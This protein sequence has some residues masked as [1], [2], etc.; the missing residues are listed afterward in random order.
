[1]SAPLIVTAARHTGGV[2][3]LS[4]AAGDGAPLASFTPGSH[5]TVEAGGRCNAY[6]LTG[7]YLNPR[8]YDISVLATPDGTGS[9]WLHERVE[10]GD[11]LMVSPPR[12]AFA[13][14]AAARHHVLVAGG[15]GVTPILS[16]VRA[17]VRHQRSFEVLYAHRSD[18]PAH[19]E[20]LIALCGPRLATVTDRHEL[21]SR[22]RLRL[23]SQP[24]GTVLSLCG[25][26]AMMA[27]VVELAG[28]LG[29]PGQRILTEAFGVDV[30]DPGQPFTARLRRSGRRI[31][32]A[33]GVSLLEALEADGVRVPN[34]CRQGVCGECRVPVAAGRPEHR[35][36]YLS[37]DER[38]AGDCLMACVSR[39]DGDLLELNL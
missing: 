11:R 1:M 8:T 14:V 15:I 21:I 35:D 25:P 17:A 22:L 29:W 26:A 27:S 38:A 31:P 37:D 7:E 36:L 19:L 32:V 39:C 9:R 24:L 18:Q 16:H 2:R 12:S 13:P 34:M 4:L 23:S 20:D 30:L 10:V 28:S 3:H 33:S 5:I 6:S